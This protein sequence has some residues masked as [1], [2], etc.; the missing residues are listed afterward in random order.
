MNIARRQ[1]LSLA[2]AAFAFLAMPHTAWSQQYPSRPVRI[3]V[4][5]TAGSAPDTF[6]RLIGQWLS[7]RLG[8]PFIVENRPGAGSKVATEAVVQSPPDGHTLLLVVPANAIGAALHENLSYNFIR[9][10]A[11]VAE[12]VR[13]PFVM[14]ANLSLPAKTIPEL[15]E[16]SKSN[17]G[18]LN[19]ASSG[20]GTGDHMSGELFKAMTGVEMAHVPYPGPSQAMTDLLAGRVQVMFSSLASAVEHIKAGKTQ[21]L[22]VTSRERSPALPNIPSVSEFVPGYEASAFFG[23]GA[24][25]STPAS[26]V[27]ALNQAINAGLSDPKIKAQLAAMSATPSVGSPEEF[28][29]LI[30]NETE[31]W[32]KIIKSAGIK[33]M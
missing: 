17:P 31:K 6:A 10:V 28:G 26:I 19:M 20:I 11:P 9:D 21:A 5:F 4:G 12:L 1:L 33:A 8:Q 25:R 23:I 2:A 13:V 24:P 18:K 29:R 16:Y 32:T 22:A 27:E 15:I 14:Q 3:V 30:A 7:D